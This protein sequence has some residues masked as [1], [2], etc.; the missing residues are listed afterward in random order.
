MPPPSRLRRAATSMKSRRCLS[1]AAFA[2]GGLALALLLVTIIGLGVLLQP[3]P[4]AARHQRFQAQRLTAGAGRAADGQLGGRQRRRT[5][6]DGQ[7]RGNPDRRHRVAE[8]ADRHVVAGWRGDSRAG[9]GLRHAADRRPAT[10]CRSS[11]RSRS[12]PSRSIRRRWCCTSRRRS[13]STGLRRAR[14]APASAGWKASP[15]RRSTPPTASRRASRSWASRRGP[16]TLTLTAQNDDTTVQQPLTVEMIA[17]QC[18]ASS[19]DASL[20][21]SPDPDRS[22]YRDDPA[23]DDRDRRCAGRAESM[24]ARPVAR[25]ARTAGA[26][27]RPSPA[28][29]PSRSMTC[30]KN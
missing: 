11:S 9:R 15:A 7:R 27:A 4:R 20:R 6:S 13:R 3:A 17:P 12:R 29:T 28:P 2:L 24:A 23:G 18:S 1:W 25:A 21:A 22:G 19:G 30:T 14:T 5:A 10:P 8:R 26:S 16:L